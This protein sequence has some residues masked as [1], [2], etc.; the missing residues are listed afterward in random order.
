MFQLVI[1]CKEDHFD[2]DSESIYAPSVNDIMRAK[3]CNGKKFTNF[4][5]NEIQMF[6]KDIEFIEDE[7]VIILK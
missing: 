4:G 3:V 7:E 5:P 2:I 6:G 1:F